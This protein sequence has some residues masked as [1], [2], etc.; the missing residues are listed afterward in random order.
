MI[1]GTTTTHNPKEIISKDSS[2]AFGITYKPYK[3]KVVVSYHV[4]EEED[5]EL[6]ADVSQRI[7]KLTTKRDID[8]MMMMNLT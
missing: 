4:P 8:E 3:S 1:M 2:D 7:E 5:E 6:N